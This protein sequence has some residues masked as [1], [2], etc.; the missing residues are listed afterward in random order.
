MLAQGR[1]NLKSAEGLLRDQERNVIGAAVLAWD[2][3]FDILAGFMNLAG[4]RITSQGG[5]HSVALAGVR[6]I[7]GQERR[8]LLNRL[9]D[10]RRTRNRALYDAIPPDADEIEAVIRDVRSIARELES[11]LRRFEAC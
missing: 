3:A 5:H 9:G 4:Y 10:L 1:L 8:P 7:L 6:A 11:A 2:G